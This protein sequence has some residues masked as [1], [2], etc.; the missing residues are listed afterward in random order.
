MAKKFAELQ[1]QMSPE[2]RA[3][4]EAATQQMLLEMNL[5]E[6]RT[7]MSS[8]SQGDL[9]KLLEV[10]QGYVSRLERTKDMSVRRLYDY[11][12]TVG[13]RLEIRAKFPNKPDVVISQFDEVGSLFEEQHA[14]A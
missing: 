1:A 9:A 11:V 13:G 5:Q 12:Q 3:A 4:S 10:T 14:M 8:L 7:Q 6:L 2:R